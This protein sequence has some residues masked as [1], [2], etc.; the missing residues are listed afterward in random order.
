ML[1]INK[2][3]FS[4]SNG[5]K[6]GH[7]F[8]ARASSLRVLKSPPKMINNQFSENEKLGN[9]SPLPKSELANDEIYQKFLSDYR[10]ATAERLISFMI[11]PK[12]SLPNARN[13]KKMA[14]EVSHSDGTFI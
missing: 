10:C 3:I 6:L 2:I 4:A 1:N 7:P 13:V 5:H 11:N 9:T 12:I 14:I 8:L